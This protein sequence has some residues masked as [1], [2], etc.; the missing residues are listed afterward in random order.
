M[1]CLPWTR[2]NGGSITRLSSPFAKLVKG[3]FPVAAASS[4]S[5]WVFSVAG[6]VVTP[7]RAN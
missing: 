2:W 4:K 3:V 7:K 1:S 5:E 6:N